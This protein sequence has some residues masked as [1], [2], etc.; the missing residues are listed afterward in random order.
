MVMKFAQS[1]LFIVLFILFLVFV[2]YQ[3]KIDR[4]EP[5]YEE[6][7]IA[8]IQDTVQ[9]RPP[10]LLYGFPVDSFTVIE[11][12]IRRNQFLGEIL[13]EYQVT[14]QQIHNLSMKSRNVYDVRKLEARKKYT[15]LC[16]RD[17]LPRAE[18]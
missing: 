4:S 16:T 15:I 11:N 12:T 8:E 14:D 17:S 3:I 10:A 13:S 6:E 5:Q 18:Y 2:V 1:G 7:V 9:I